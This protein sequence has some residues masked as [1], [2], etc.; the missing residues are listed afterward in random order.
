MIKAMIKFI[1][2][3]GDNIKYIKDVFKK[4]VKNSNKKI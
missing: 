4:R 1:S 2:E 3:T